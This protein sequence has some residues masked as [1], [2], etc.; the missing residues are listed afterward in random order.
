MTSDKPPNP[1]R[2]FLHFW[3]KYNRSPHQANVICGF[4]KPDYPLPDSFRFVSIG[5]QEDWP[6]ERWSERL[7]N[8]CETIAD[9]VFI[10]MMD[11]YWLVRD[12]DSTALKIL[13]D[14]MHQF[15]NV[16]KIDLTFDRLFAEG[17]GRYLY[18]YNT[19]ETAGYLDLIKSNHGSAYHMSLWGGMWRRDLLNKVLIPG[20]TAQQIELNGT[21]RLSMMGD[22]VLVLGTRQAPMR[23]INAI[24][25]RDWNYQES[26]LHGMKRHDL[27]ALPGLGYELGERL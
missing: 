2:G 8:V 23:H 24:Q 11:D 1:L 16:L 7:H 25:G 22:E 13:Y 5:K 27:E 14:Y 3:Q 15:T 19:Y 6:K 20:E 21:T 12:T 10:L 9:D 26:G 4:T 18:G 17:G